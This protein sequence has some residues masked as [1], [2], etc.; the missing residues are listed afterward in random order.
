MIEMTTNYGTMIFEL[1]NE[2]PLHRDN[3]V[4][5]VNDK[6]YDS[7]LFHRVIE[8]F[9]I[10]GGDPDSRHA[11]SGVILG[12]GDLEYSVAAEFRSNLFHKKGAL[13]TAREETLGR[14]SSAMQFFVVQGKVYNDSLLD[15]AELRINKM[16][17]RHYLLNQPENEKLWADLKNAE[18][19]ETKYTVLNDSINAMV[20]TF[21]D[22]EPYRIPESHR[23]VYKTIGG[24]PHLDQNYTVF[25]QVIE[26]L[27]VIDS[28]AKVKTDKWDRPTKNVRILSVRIKTN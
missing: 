13:S 17:A 6:A 23:E 27:D 8:S 26:G 9:M 15:N 19:D 1:Y 14:V 18:E 24:T 20:Q 22:F 4:K 2:T 5:L 10:Q 11:K 3:F 12:E 28:I 21:T 25:G 7:L 16:L